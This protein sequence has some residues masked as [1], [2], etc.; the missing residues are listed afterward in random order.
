MTIGD[1]RFRVCTCGKAYSV[2]TWRELP[3]CGIVDV[4]KDYPARPGEKVIPPIELRTCSR[5][6]ST[7]SIRIPYEGGSD[8]PLPAPSSH[9]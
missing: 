5:C 7:I 9:R 2:A 8:Y 3:R 6:S 1:D 4:E